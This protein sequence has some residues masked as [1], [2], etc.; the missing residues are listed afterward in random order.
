MIVQVEEQYLI[1]S[2]AQELVSVLLY[3]VV[4]VIVGN[5]APLLQ[6]ICAVTEAVSNLVPA[7]AVLVETLAH[8]LT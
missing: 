4:A 6:T 3:L 5:H 7:I 8:T 2:V 1:S